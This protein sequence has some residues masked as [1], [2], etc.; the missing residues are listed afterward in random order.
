[1]RNI[2]NDYKVTFVDNGSK[3]LDQCNIECPSIILMDIKMPVL[4]G[5]EAMKTIKAN[6]KFAHIP[7]IAVTALAMK[8]E[9]E[10]LINFGFDDYVSKPIDRSKL[11]DVLEKHSK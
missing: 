3:V 11:I 4:D 2:L 6:S 10:N 1:M 5:K 7:I 9:K 8:G